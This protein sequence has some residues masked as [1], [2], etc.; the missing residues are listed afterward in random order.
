MRGSSRFPVLTPCSNPGEY[1]QSGFLE[2][3][4]RRVWWE[5]ASPEGQK[6]WVLVPAPLCDL[7]QV[8]PA[9]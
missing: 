9:L 4:P 5:D 2:P 8:T 3:Q 6:L 7:E 1:G